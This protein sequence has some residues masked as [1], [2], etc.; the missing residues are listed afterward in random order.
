MLIDTHSHLYAEEF[1]L[2]RPEVLA[3]ARAAG[4][5]HILLPAIDKLSY[6]R[7]DA[8]TRQHPD[9]LH[10]MMGLHPTSVGADFEADLRLA[11]D[12]LFAAPD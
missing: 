7:Q 10:Q 1:D 11:H 2:D 12:R 4:I 5:G 8:L 9:C 6:D 3:R